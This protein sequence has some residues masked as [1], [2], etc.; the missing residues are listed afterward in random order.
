[1]ANVVLIVHLDIAESAFEEFLDIVRAHGERSQALEAGCLGFDVLVD[2]ERANH[3]VLVET[4][5]DAEAL[6][7]HWDSAHMAEYRDKTGAMTLS[8]DRYMCE[9]R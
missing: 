9:P 3:V 2:R 4:Y 7:A 8:R 1:M 6:Q 5:R